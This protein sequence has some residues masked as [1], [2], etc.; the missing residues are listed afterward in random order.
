MANSG[1]PV[2]I[3]LGSYEVE[4]S[5]SGTCSA[6]QVEVL[7]RL[8]HVVEPLG[9]TDLFHYPFQNQEARDTTDTATI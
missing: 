2:G 4:S 5:P 8:W 3:W 6:N 7:T 1:A 9:I